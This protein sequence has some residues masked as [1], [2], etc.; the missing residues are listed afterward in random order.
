MSEMKKVISSTIF[1]YLLD[2]AAYGMGK[3]A[4]VPVSV[5]RAT[6]LVKR[7][8]CLHGGGVWWRSSTANTSRTNNNVINWQIEQFSGDTNQLLWSHQKGKFH[9]A[10]NLLAPVSFKENRLFKSIEDLELQNHLK[11]TADLSRRTMKGR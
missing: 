5:A 10:K 6:V 8:P 2:T 4:E 9:I 1:R 7:I 11:K 3:L